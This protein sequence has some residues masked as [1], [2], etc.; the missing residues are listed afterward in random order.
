MSKY[1]FGVF[2][3]KINRLNDNL[4]I[5]KEINSRKDLVKRPKVMLL[6]NKKLK[7]AINENIGTVEDHIKTL[8]YQILS[9][10]F[11]RR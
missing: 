7:L 6:S 5:R 1:S 9:D 10:R 4:L 8:N 11:S 2:L 3:A